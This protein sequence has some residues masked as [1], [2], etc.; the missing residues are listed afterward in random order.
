MR[1][2]RTLAASPTVSL[3]GSH[4]RDS[5]CLLHLRLEWKGLPL[6]L[7]VLHPLVGLRLQEVPPVAL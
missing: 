7:E 4:R 6:A 1:G 2:C 5:L 3:G